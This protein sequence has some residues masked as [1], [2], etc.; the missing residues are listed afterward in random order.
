MTPKDLQSTLQVL[1][2]M[3]AV[4]LALASLYKTCGETFPEDQLFWAGI[5]RQEEI[6][7]QSIGTMAELVAQRPQEFDFG[8]AFN[9][10]KIAHIRSI[11][12]NYSD[13]VKNQEITRHK[14]LLIACDIEES[15]LE[16]NYCKVLKTSNAQFMAVMET[17]DK[18]TAIH[19]NLFA[20]K[21]AQ[22]KP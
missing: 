16:A 22:T 11:I 21:L 20:K 6:H 17:L 2:D 19:K 13:Q 12:D 9:S 1:N 4:E 15:V 10:I 8:S 7:A 14:T 5:A 3:A 18:D